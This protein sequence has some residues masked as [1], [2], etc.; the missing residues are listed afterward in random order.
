[1]LFYREKIIYRGIVFTAVR[2]VSN[3]ELYKQMSEN[4]GFCSFALDSAHVKFDV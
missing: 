2:P 1:M 3:V 4:N